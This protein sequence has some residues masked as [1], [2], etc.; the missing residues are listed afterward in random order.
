MKIL[1]YLL[2]FKRKYPMTIGRRL[3]KHAKVVERHLNS[4]EKVLYAFYAQKNDNPIDIITTSAIVLTNKR[5]LVGQK[6]VV[7]GY[8]FYSITPDLFNDLQVRVGPVWG[9]IYVDTVKELVI[10]SN[11]DKRALPEIETKITGFMME[12][13]KKYHSRKHIEI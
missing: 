6:R 7:F 4:G 1:E 12:E 10:L 9:K 11:I 13:K 5:L 3:S 2:E 8:F